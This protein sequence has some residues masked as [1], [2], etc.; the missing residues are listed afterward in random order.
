[1]HKWIIFLLFLCPCFL[2][3]EYKETRRITVPASELPLLLQQGADRV[4]MP[5]TEFHELLEKV[6][7]QR[8]IS[9]TQT[10]SYPHPIHIEVTL[11]FEEDHVVVEADCLIAGTH[12]GLN[13]VDLDFDHVYWTSAEIE[14]TPAEVGGTPGKATQVFFEGVEERRLTLKGVSPL[15]K[16]QNRQQL[17]LKVPQVPGKTILLAP[18]GMDMT[19]S[20]HEGHVVPFSGELRSEIP[21]VEPHVLL[22]DKGWIRGD[23]RL[24]RLFRADPLA[25]TT[26]YI[27]FSRFSGQ[28][29]DL[30]E[31]IDVF[32]HHQPVMQ[33][34]L[35]LPADVQVR[36]VSCKEP[37]DWQSDV[38]G[39]I[40]KITVEFRNEVIGPVGLEVQALRKH[41]QADQWQPVRFHVENSIKNIRFQGLAV[42]RPWSVSS[43]QNGDASMV[44]A[45][46]RVEGSWMTRV[47][48][49]VSG[50]N[51]FAW[52]LSE[53][54]AAPSVQMRRKK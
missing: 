25:L 14:G 44:S 16:E 27:Q 47:N 46:T 19:E 15:P 10:Q 9:G 5:A 35:S 4:L 43:V 41:Q 3:A 50:R 45:F 34:V 49:T 38:E 31:R 42:E 36:T 26:Q 40:R 8:E 28:Y 30:T 20:I 24:D 54:G 1:M 2:Q 53:T 51:L 11:S 12:P 32:V 23:I 48:P 21:G 29:E 13:R 6:K 52:K 17:A 39:D 37:M 22:A 18:A 33:L 7:Q